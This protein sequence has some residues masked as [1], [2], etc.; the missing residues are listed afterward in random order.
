MTLFLEEACHEQGKLL[1]EPFGTGSRH[2][3]FRS[4]DGGIA[5]L[6]AIEYS[7]VHD[8]IIYFDDILIYSKSLDE[9]VE[10]LKQVF[11]IL[12]QEKLYANLK[13]CTFCN[14]HIIFLGFVVSANGVQVDEEKV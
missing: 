13:T 14:D 9:H 5:P 6:I 12:K 2:R 7:T 4:V 1:L 10:H 11:R 3:T 8:R